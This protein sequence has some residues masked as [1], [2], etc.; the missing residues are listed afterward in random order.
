[1]P[2]MDRPS[3]RITTNFHR[4]VLLLLSRPLRRAIFPTTLSNKSSLANVNLLTLSAVN[5]ELLPLQAAGSAASAVI[6]LALRHLCPLLLLSLLTSCRSS[7]FFQAHRHN[8]VLTL[9][10]HPPAHRRTLRFRHN[11]PFTR[12]LL[13]GLSISSQL[14]LVT[15]Y[16]SD[17]YK[18]TFNKRLQQVYASCS[19][20]T[21]RRVLSLGHLALAYHLLLTSLNHSYRHH[22]RVAF[23]KTLLVRARLR[24][25]PSMRPGYEPLL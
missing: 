10:S 21:Y 6:S 8:I 15:Q 5:A 4:Q 2:V 3:N 7:P 22:H 14:Q 23:L 24:P 20:L 13:A 16:P 18:P 17:R 1:M 19:T 12:L 9:V 25:S 11:T